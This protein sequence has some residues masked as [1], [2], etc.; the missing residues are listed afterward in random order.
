MKPIVLNFLCN[1][2]DNVILNFSPRQTGMNKFIFT[3]AL[4]LFLPGLQAADDAAEVVSFRCSLAINATF[5]ELDEQ[6][7]NPVTQEAINKIDEN[8]AQLACI[9][10]PDS[11]IYIRLQW[12]DMLPTENK[13][14]FTI[15]TRSYRVIKTQFGP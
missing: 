11:K 13:L 9:K 2:P 14:V 1:I 15:D 10:G 8:T 3:A 5:A 6:A 12:P 4:M 7:D